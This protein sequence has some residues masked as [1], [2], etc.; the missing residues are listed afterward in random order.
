[1]KTEVV[2]ES[3]PI[4]DILSLPTRLLGSVLPFWEIS[5]ESLSYWENRNHP[6]NDFWADE[7]LGEESEWTP[8]LISDERCEPSH[9]EFVLRF[10]ITSIGS[11]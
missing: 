6:H 10:V 2:S 3:P 1:M 7:K 11:I 4:N 5:P 8:L 9:V